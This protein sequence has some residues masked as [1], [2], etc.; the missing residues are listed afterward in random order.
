MREW[1]QQNIIIK[2][3]TWFVRGIVNRE[4]ELY[5]VLDEKSI[6]TAEIKDSKK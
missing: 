6:T 1:K 5:D 3:A 2:Y 4:E